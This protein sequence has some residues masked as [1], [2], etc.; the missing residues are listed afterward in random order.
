MARLFGA[1]FSTL[2]N[3]SAIAQVSRSFT[4]WSMAFVKTKKLDRAA[5]V[6]VAITLDKM[7]NY[8]AIQVRWLCQ[9]RSSCWCI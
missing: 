7:L 2:A 5:M 4:T 6:Y 1:I 9:S 3:S 8:N